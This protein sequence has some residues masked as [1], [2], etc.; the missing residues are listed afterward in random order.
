FRQK[1]LLAASITSRRIEDLICRLRLMNPARGG[2]SKRPRHIDR[3]ILTQQ[4]LSTLDLGFALMSTTE[5][6]KKRCDDV[7]KLAPSP[8][9]TSFGISDSFC[10]RTTRG[11]AEHGR[12]K[13]LAAAQ[14]RH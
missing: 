4:S 14:L 6:L 11:M 12:K 1:R 7:G 3:T 5:F 9:Q 10:L 8:K 2:T 13:I